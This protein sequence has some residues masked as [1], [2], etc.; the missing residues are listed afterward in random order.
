MALDLK[1][2]DEIARIAAE[3]IAI[4]DIDIKDHIRTNLALYHYSEGL[5]LDEQNY[6]HQALIE[7][8]RSL[9][10]NY[11]SEETRFA[12]ARI[13]KKLDFPIMYLM[14]L[15]VLKDDYHTK[16][17]KVLDEFELHLMYYYDSVSYRWIDELKAV[18]GEKS[19]S[20]K[21]TKSG[22][23]EIFD[24]YSM[25]WNRKFIYILVRAFKVWYECLSPKPIQIR[26]IF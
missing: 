23:E 24:Q 11:D 6:M 21:Q 10:L 9:M 22:D 16:E 1:Y 18:T 13:Y 2:D 12:Y 20:D 25:F 7:Y 5:L 3:N 4:K 26:I 8:R 19:M 15:K 17:K 14:E